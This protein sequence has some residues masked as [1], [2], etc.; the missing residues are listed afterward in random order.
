MSRTF[1]NVLNLVK[2]NA[3]RQIENTS[4][5]RW[6]LHLREGPSTYKYE[7]GQMANFFQNLSYSFFI[8]LPSEFV[9]VL[10]RLTR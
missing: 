4:E 7:Q 10:G 9:P 2:S 3:S 5:L 6:M 1:L 8:G